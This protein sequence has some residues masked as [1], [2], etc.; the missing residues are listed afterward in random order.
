MSAIA[1]PTP[2]ST[3]PAVTASAAPT[4]TAGAGSTGGAE[5]VGSPQTGSG[6]VSAQLLCGGTTSLASCASSLATPG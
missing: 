6:G 4:P 5:P 3:A 1:D 2:N